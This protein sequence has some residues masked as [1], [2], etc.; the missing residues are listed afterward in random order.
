MW[1]CIMQ[2]AVRIFQRLL[3]RLSNM[4]WVVVKSALDFTKYFG[5]PLLDALIRS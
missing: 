1:A 2:V 3:Q 5:L 4:V